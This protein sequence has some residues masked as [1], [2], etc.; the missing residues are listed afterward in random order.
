MN[1]LE[2]TKKQSLYQ[3]ISEQDK[4]SS[5]SNTTKEIKTFWEKRQTN[6]K[7]NYWDSLKLFNTFSLFYNCCLI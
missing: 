5:S 6:K 2:G 7:H 3:A 1:Q 4:Q